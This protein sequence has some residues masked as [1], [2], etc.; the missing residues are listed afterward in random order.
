MDF[1]NKLR[2]LVLAQ[3]ALANR[4]PNELAV[5][6]EGLTE[7]LGVAMVVAHRD[8]LPALDQACTA[9]E[10]AIHRSAVQQLET[11]RALGALDPDPEG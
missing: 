11:L 9:L 3:L 7:M 1:T 10:G 8:D 5:V 2:A 4:D 6:V